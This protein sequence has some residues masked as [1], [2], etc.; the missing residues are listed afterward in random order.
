MQGQEL[1]GPRH[2]QT[3]ESWLDVSGRDDVEGHLSEDR[4]HTLAIA[5]CQSDYIA[6]LE[7]QNYYFAVGGFLLSCEDEWLEYLASSHHNALSDSSHLRP[8]YHN[9]FL[10]ETVIRMA[11]EMFMNYLGDLLRLILVAKPETLRSS[12]QVKVED[13]LRHANLDSFVGWYADRKVNELSYLSLVDLDDFFTQR[14]GLPICTDQAALLEARRLIA[15]RN[16][17]VHARGVINPVYRKAADE[18]DA[19]LGEKLSL[20]ADEATHAPGSVYR[21]A[22]SLDSRASAKFQLRCGCLHRTSART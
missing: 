12:A 3:A 17:I 20:D 16:L 10:A 1:C 4:G 11:A 19:P 13:V 7:F 6:I 18:P 15:K 5:G 9:D 2:I 8:G 21:L 14:L 22:L